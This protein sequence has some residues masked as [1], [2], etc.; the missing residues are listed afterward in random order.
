MDESQLLYKRVVVKVKPSRKKRSVHASNGHGFGF[1]N[2]ESLNKDSRYRTIWGAFLVDPKNPT[3]YLRI[4]STCVSAC[5]PLGCF[6][7][8][9]STDFTTAP[10]GE[11][12]PI[13][14]DRS[15]YLSPPISYS[16]RPA[17]VCPTPLSQRSVNSAANRPGKPGEKPAEKPMGKRMGKN[18]IRSVWI[19]VRM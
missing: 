2:F 4:F 16:R 1:D 12:I 9:V 15:Y 8:L 3:V 17:L 18:R 13:T 11:C 6:C 14:S 10:N 5:F 7:R 19:I